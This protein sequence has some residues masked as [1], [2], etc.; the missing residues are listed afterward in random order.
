MHR[1]LRDQGVPENDIIV[2]VSNMVIKDPLRV[3][4]LTIRQIPATEA[5]IYATQQLQKDGIN[6]N[7]CYVTSLIHAVACA[8]AKAI[9]ISV[10][11]GPVRIHRTIATTPLISGTKL[12]EMYERRR[13]TVYP[14]PSKHPGIETVQSILAYFKLHGIR[15]K[16]IGT[17]FR[18]V[19]SPF[20]TVCPRAHS[21][22]KPSN[23]D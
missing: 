8:E 3:A 5:G 21:W 12:L 11:V 9:A 17:R 10:S 19:S 23:I 4:W 1:L 13:K 2:S 20:H 7:L 22:R 16:V 6:V 18:T 15:T 14:D